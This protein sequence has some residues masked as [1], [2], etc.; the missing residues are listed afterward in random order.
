MHKV[1]SVIF[2]KSAWTE[3]KARAWLKK[4]NYESEGKVHIT[5]EH[6]RFRQRAPSDFKKSGYYTVSLPNNVEL[7][8]GDRKPKKPEKKE[9][10][11]KEDVQ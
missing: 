2:K 9:K 5:E 1:Q 4:H 7:I 8:I 11:E 10:E 3:S 6:I